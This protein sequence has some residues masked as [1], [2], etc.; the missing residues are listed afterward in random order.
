[1]GSSLGPKRGRKKRQYEDKD[2]E[3]NRK[4]VSETIC[5]DCTI[6]QIELFVCSR[7]FIVDVCVCVP[8]KTNCIRRAKQFPYHIYA[9]KQFFKIR[10]ELLLLLLIFFS[11]HLIARYN[12][13]MFIYTI[14]SFSLLW[15]PTICVMNKSNQ[16]FPVWIYNRSSKL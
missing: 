9:I 1:M 7:A 13:S 3:M 15:F 11:F 5:M 2:D 4:I 12:L 14:Q 10:V 8:L 6:Q 16:V